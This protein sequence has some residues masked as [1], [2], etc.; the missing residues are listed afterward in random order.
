MPATKSKGPRDTHD[1][2]DY[3]SPRNCMILTV[4]G[5]TK[6]AGYREWQLFGRQVRRGEHGIALLAP[7]VK[8]N[9]DGSSRVV[10]TRTV[11]VFDVAQTEQ[12]A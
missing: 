9:D 3:Y 2:P 7:V 4:A 10:N 12:A 6:V 11:K 5:A 8:K 1:W